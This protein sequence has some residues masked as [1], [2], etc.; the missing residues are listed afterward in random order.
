MV[1]F[2]KR[3]I[4]LTKNKRIFLKAFGTFLL[5]IGLYLGLAAMR[6]KYMEKTTNVNAALHDNRTLLIIYKPK[7]KRCK[8]ILIP[9]YIKKALTLRRE[10]V[11]NANKLTDKQIEKY[12]LIRK[13]PTFRYHLKNYE[14]MN[15]NDAEKIWFHTH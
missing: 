1:H 11:I 2:L 5:I 8:N 14:P 12:N 3:N 7:C 4:S 10:N 9:L 6:F 13:T 15:L